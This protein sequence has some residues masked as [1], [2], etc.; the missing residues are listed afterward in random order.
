MYIIQMHSGNSGIFFQEPTKGD[1]PKD[2]NLLHAKVFDTFNQAM[3]VANVILYVCPEKPLVI[4]ELADGKI[5]QAWPTV[6]GL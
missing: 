5:T 6:T 2:F 1:K 4:L 3:S